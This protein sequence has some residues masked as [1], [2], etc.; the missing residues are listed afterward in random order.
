[1]PEEAIPWVGVRGQGLRFDK[2]IHDMEDKKLLGQQTNKPQ[3]ISW[4][5]K[6]S[7][8]MDRKIK[9]GL[10]LHSVYYTSV[11]IASSNTAWLYDVEIHFSPPASKNSNS[12]HPH[13]VPKGRGH[14]FNGSIYL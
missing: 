11:D 5:L 3:N 8:C 7:T 14:G 10:L 4:L 1:M 2:E 9:L 13:I 12:I 6:N